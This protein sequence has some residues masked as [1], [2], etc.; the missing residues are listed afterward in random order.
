M[1]WSEAAKE[2]I[3]ALQPVQINESLL[4]RLY[5]LV[6][7]TSLNDNDNEA[8]IA[9]FCEKAR[10]ALGHVAA[11]CIYPSFVPLAVAQFAGTPVKVATVANFPAGNMPLDEVLVEIGRSLQDGAQEMDVVFPYSRYLAGERQY[12]QTFV[13]SCKAACGEE[14][15]LKVILETGALRDTAIIADAAYDALTGGAD[16]VKTSTGKIS[17]GVTLE[18]AAVMLLVIRH[19]A[20]QLKRPLGFKASGGIRDIHQAAQYVELADRI[21]GQSWVTPATFRIGASKLVDE[22]LAR[23][24]LVH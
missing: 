17:E 14:V 13:A 7:L 3:D 6:D 2:Y 9:S 8:G 5:G 21:M 15:L 12:A 24:R 20:S 19:A 18:A 10:S 16:F 4:R 1:Q 23:Q 22:M 11:V